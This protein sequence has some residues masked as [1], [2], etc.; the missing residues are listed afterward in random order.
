VS[1]S[2]DGQAERE[3]CCPR[4]TNGNTS[5]QSAVDDYVSVTI[6]GIHDNVIPLPIPGLELL[7]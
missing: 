5:P 3:G 4:G 2:R 7:R 6:A 1:G